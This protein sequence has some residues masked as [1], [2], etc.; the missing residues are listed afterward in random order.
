MRT[1]N[2]H[3]SLAQRFGL[4]RGS[5]ASSG[6]MGGAGDAT[7][8]QTSSRPTS[9]FLT[10]LGQNPL[11][12]A[13][14]AAGLAMMA[15]LWLLFAF[16]SLWF[17][18]GVMVLSAAFLCLSSFVYWRNAA[19]ERGFASD[20]NPSVSGRSSL[21][22]TPQGELTAIDPGLQAKLELPGDPCEV[23]GALQVKVNDP[24]ALKRLLAAATSGLV[25]EEVLA[26]GLSDG[27]T[28]HFLG[29]VNP[30]PGGGARL[31]FVDVSLLQVAIETEKGG[32]KWFS[33]FMEAL[34]FGVFALDDDGAIIFANAMLRDRLGLS[35][36]DVQEGRRRFSEFLDIRGR[37]RGD[38]ED[39]LTVEGVQGRFRAAISEVSGDAGYDG[40]RRFV[41]MP[42][43]E[44]TPDIAKGEEA[45]VGS[46]SGV[47]VGGLRALFEDAPVGVLLADAGGA[48]THCNRAFYKLLGQH[49]DLIVGKSIS[50]L[51]APEDR[52][53]LNAQLSK[54]VMGTA[55]V[56]HLE[57]NIPA[58][59]ER[60]LMTSLF[61]GRLEDDLGDMTGL[62]VHVLDNTERKIWK[63]NSGKAK[64]CRRSGNSPAGSP[65]ISTIC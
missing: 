24:A 45:T 47:A 54:I 10:V 26:F 32:R 48:V 39:W 23:L 27:R 19:T 44:L 65:M 37:D 51:V 49:R 33:D 31:Q 15:A 59:G 46:G 4:L 25:R 50:E 12:S 43:T 11:P 52:A 60:L 64:R 30:A 38:G 7:S 63:S 5:A 29:L 14:L 58:A 28:R 42:A 34:P 1:L 3:R 20:A 18:I 53:D 2:Q 22:L 6:L 16:G 9:G 36:P 62:V 56:A 55:R 61:A 8:P 35:I 17:P 21:T 40:P 41:L 57:V 13:L